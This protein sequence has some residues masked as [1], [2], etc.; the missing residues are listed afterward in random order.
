[1]AAAL[2]QGCHTA[3]P[4]PAEGVRAPALIQLEAPT[5]ITI[6]PVEDLRPHS[7]TS[8]RPTRLQ[9][10]V[11]RFAGDTILFARFVI[12]SDYQG[13]PECQW[14]GCSYVLVSESPMLELK[15]MRISVL[16]TLGLVYLLSPFALLFIGRA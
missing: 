2:D 6:R 10:A 11:E 13:A 9:G 5:G 7:L 12:M 3:R 15:S 1:M 4:V 8:C 14:S 16:R